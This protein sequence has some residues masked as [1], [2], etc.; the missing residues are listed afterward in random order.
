MRLDKGLG[1]KVIT[2]LEG[3]WDGVMCGDDEDVRALAALVLGK[4]EVEI[5]MEMEELNKTILGEF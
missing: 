1:Q 2:L 4:A 5:A 3:I